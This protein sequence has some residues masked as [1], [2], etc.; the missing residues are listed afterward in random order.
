AFRIFKGNTE[1]ERTTNLITSLRYLNVSFQESPSME[2]DSIDFFSN[3]IFV[4]STIGIASRQFV[5]DQYI[6][7]DGR[8]EDVPVGSIYALTFGNQYKND[9][10]RV[11]LGAR[12]A[13]G[14]YFNWGYLSSNMEFGS[15]LN[16][17]KL[18]QTVF[19][20]QANYFTRLISLGNW[21]MRQF[22]KPQ[23]VLGSNRLDSSADRVSLD[24]NRNPSG[25]YGDNFR[26]LNEARIPG[27]NGE[28]LGTSKY[29]L[30]LQTQFYS[31]WEVYGF[32]LNPYI[33]ITGGFIADNKSVFD[34]SNQLYTAFGLGFLVRNDYLVFSTFQFSF[35]YYPT[36]PGRG[37]NLIYTNSFET[38]DFG[39]QDFNLGKPLRVRYN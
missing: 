25:Y 7:N 22:V 33:N 34:N 37:N 28:L 13:L 19:S 32:R 21:K 23:F 2:Y 17:G 31:P 26:Q 15:F 9:Q 4:L 10:N 20:F 36:I 8:I 3:Q 35:S 39:F 38:E 6:F 27:F 11:Y 30:A 12:V 18:E 16:K 1:Q 24:D 5:Q 14:K 29:V